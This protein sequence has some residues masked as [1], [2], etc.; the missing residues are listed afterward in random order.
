MTRDQFDT[1]VAKLDWQARSTPRFYRFKVLMLA[2]LG[3]AYAVGALLGVVVFMGGAVLVL[4]ALAI[5]V[6]LICGVFIGQIVKSLW[7]KVSP[8]QGVEASSLRSPELFAMID[9]LRRQLRAP[10]FHRVLITDDHNAGISQ[11]PRLGLFG[12]Y[13]NYLMIGLPLLQTL[14]V[15]QFRAVLAHEFGH[16][17]RGHGSFGNWIYCQRLRWAQLL[18]SL[19]Q[20]PT[21]GDFLFKPF[22]NWYSGY[23]SA[24]T[25]PLA[26]SNEYEADATS[27]RLTSRETVAAALTG[28]EVIATYLSES[29][30]PQI[31]RKADDLPLPE[32]T[33]YRSMSQ[34]VGADVDS[35]SAKKWLDRATAAKTDSSNTH[36]ALADRLHAVGAKPLL[37]P[38]APGESADR[39]LGDA[40]LSLAEHFDE[41]WQSL[42]RPS[43]EERHRKVQE[44]RRVIAE[45]DEKHD[46]GAEL[47]V[48]EAFNRALLT[49]SVRDQ[50]DVALEQMRIVHAREPG[51]PLYCLALG[52]RLLDRD[53][54]AGIEIIKGAL[55]NDDHVT[56]R[57]AE[58][59]RDYNW[60]HGRNA[61]AENWH[62]YLVARARPLQA[63]E[64]ERNELLPGN[65]FKPHG[66]SEQE[67]ADFKSRL[68]TIAGIR[69]AYLVQKVLAHF[70]ERVCYV[71]G[72]ST[73]PWYMPTRKSRNV[74]IQQAI[75][76]KMIFPGETMIV[77]IDGDLK[78]FEK[79]MKKVRGSKAL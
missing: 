79:K 30:W 36:P 51:N 60:R 63:A 54:D 6:L 7:V 66:L 47:T 53:D 31:L 74:A 77:V 14:T 3:N 70:P 39:L 67:F 1:L 19:E 75:H 28:S 68:C 38:P 12:W 2:M 21:Y 65:T 24:Y 8:P 72:Y 41:R 9:G 40:A 50:A 64:K 25:F 59:M 78:H 10:R 52:S 55:K 57:A 44:D 34:S 26:R 58:A 56:L 69:K 17:A 45:L 71:L 76:E 42:I 29:Y 32:L 18:N 16:L 11:V 73:T 61:E 46:G 20:R 4:R 48:E 23:F 15:E 49:E 27:A 33:P 22:F 62:N 5:K 43:W 35:A 13:R 37:A